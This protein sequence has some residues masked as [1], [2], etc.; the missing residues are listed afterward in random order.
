MSSS[1][2]DIKRKLTFVKTGD[3]YYQQLASVE[4][5]PPKKKRIKRSRNVPEV[6]HPITGGSQKKIAS[7]LKMI[8]RMFNTMQTLI[9][10]IS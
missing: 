2:R 6:E 7:T 5:A 4:L 10:S 9:K 1:H 8:K 3:A